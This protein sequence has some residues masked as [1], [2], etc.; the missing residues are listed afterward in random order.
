MQEKIRVIVK[1]PG[2]QPETRTIPNTLRSLK[3]LVGGY[4]EPVT[5]SPE[6]VGIVNEE[7]FIR[8]LPYNMDLCGVP[9]FGTLVLVG[10]DGEEFT[11]APAA[12]AAILTSGR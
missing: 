2:E 5:L 3:D 7:G 4:I 6:L 1:K 11:D 12:L 10:V 9:I 8:D